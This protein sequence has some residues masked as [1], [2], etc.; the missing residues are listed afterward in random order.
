[1][2]IQHILIIGVTLLVSLSSRPAMAQTPTTQWVSFYS[3]N[4]ELNNAPLPIGAVVDV[5]DPD[6]ILCGRDT[7]DE[8]GSYGFLAC[9]FDDPNTPSDEGIEPGDT[10]SF[11]INSGAAGRY[12]LPDDVQNG[13]RFEVDLPIEDGGAIPPPPQSIPEPITIILFSSGLAG[14]AAWRMKHQRRQP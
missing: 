5:Y 7:V 3:T 13:D 12:E 6:G 8:I 2:R 4:S 1:M 11:R 14:M 9:Y 10:V